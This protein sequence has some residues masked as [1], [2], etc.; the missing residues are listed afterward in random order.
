MIRSISIENF[1]SIKKTSLFLPKFGV[2]IGKNGSGKTTLLY[3]ISL[4]QK[5]VSGDNLFEALKGIAP[6]TYELFNFESDRTSSSFEI[7]VDNSQNKRYKLVFSITLDESIK[8]LIISNEILYRIEGDHQVI[9]YKRAKDGVSTYPNN[10]N[11][12][13]LVPLKTD[14]D[15]LSLRGYLNDEASDVASIISNYSIIDNLTEKKEGIY[16]VSSEKPDLKTIDGLAVSLSKNPDAFNLAI[17][18]TQ[19]IIPDFLP[20]TIGD[21][22][23]FFLDNSLQ[24]NENN[25]S[26]EGLTNYVVSWREKRTSKSYTSVSLSGG[27]LRTIF[28]IFSLFNTQSYSFFAIEEIENGMHS[29][30]I[31]KLIEQFRTQSNNKKIQMLFTTHS[32]EVL[33]YVIPQEMIY[34]KKT[35][36]EGSSY[37]VLSDSSEYELIKKELNHKNLT[38]KDLMDTGLFS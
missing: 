17:K 7:V 16:T 29:D 32:L 30:R 26:T 8:R 12:E 34:C 31:H 9:I 38:G 28:L 24:N 3:A 1:K 37:N 36:E 2:I 15:K 14:I 21:I 11:S 33:N 4:V 6:L 19:Q 22:N 18:A 27:N 10:E 13:V 5:L 20:P 25:P 35:P 23:R